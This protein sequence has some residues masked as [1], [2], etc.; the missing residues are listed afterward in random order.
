MLFSMGPTGPYSA[1]LCR[2]SRPYIMFQL[3]GLR[4]H[5]RMYVRIRGLRPLILSNVYGACGP[6]YSQLQW[7]S[8]PTVTG[9]ITVNISAISCAA[10]SFHNSFVFF[11]W[12]RKNKTLLLDILKLDIGVSCSRYRGPVRA[13]TGPFVGAVTSNMGP[14]RPCRGPYLPLLKG[15]KMW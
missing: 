3:W 9:Y 11:L 10:S 4:P 2:A 8:R 13:L 5:N 15:P 6:I 1:L 7:A 14:Y 12:E